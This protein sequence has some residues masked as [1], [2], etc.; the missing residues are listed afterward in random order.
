[1]EGD[2]LG[3][4][5]LGDDEGA[6]VGAGLGAEDGALLGDALGFSDAMFVGL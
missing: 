6:T 3:T 5:V 2:E 4:P 1:M